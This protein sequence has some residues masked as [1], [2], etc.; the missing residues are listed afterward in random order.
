MTLYRNHG[1]EI[2]RD[3]SHWTTLHAGIHIAGKKIKNSVGHLFLS[4]SP[5][6]YMLMVLMNLKGLQRNHKIFWYSMFFVGLSVLI[7]HEYE[8]KLAQF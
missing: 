4:Y 7:V 1:S 3:I 2:V 5:A 6:N 8:F